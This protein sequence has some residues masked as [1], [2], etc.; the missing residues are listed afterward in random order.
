MNILLVSCLS[1]LGRHRVV[2][3]IGMLFVAQLQVDVGVLGAQG[4]VEPRHQVADLALK[5]FNKVSKKLV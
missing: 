1:E 4:V 5:Y 2:E 3:E